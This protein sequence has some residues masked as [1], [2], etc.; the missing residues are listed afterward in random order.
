MH[1]LFYTCGMVLLWLINLLNGTGIGNAYRTTEYARLIT[2]AIIALLMALRA[3]SNGQWRASKR[4]FYILL[5]MVAL[6]IAMPLINGHGWVGLN[7]LWVFL[8][9]YLLSQTKP[10]RLTMVWVGGA[11]AVLGLAILFIFNYMDALDGWNPNSI[12]MI[13][14]FSYLVFTIPYYGAH[15]WKSRVILTLVG[16][17]YVVLI[18]PTESRSCSIAVVIALLLVFRVIPAEKVLNSRKKIF[19]ALQ[20]PLII[21]LL[22]CFLAITADIEALNNWSLDK[23]GKTFFSGRDQI[24]SETFEALLKTPLFGTGRVIS[25]LYH[26]SAIACLAAYGIVGYALW[27][28]LFYTILKDALAFHSDVC[29][30]GATT[31]FF[32]VFWQQ[33]VE[34]GLFAANPNLIPYIILGLILGRIRFLKERGNAL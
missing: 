16:A 14:L 32:V 13:G 23:L 9:T 2:F 7:Y 19:W 34:L 26:N 5:P 22:G 18:W 31:A 4:Y 3:Y 8:V 28:G 1:T 33:S 15:G 17:A 11:Y 6:F 12:A 10:T 20:V 30:I 25:G 21:A 24:W 29:V 27:I